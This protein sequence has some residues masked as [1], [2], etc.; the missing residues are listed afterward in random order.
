VRAVRVVSVFPA[1]TSTQPRA[2]R[3]IRTSTKENSDRTKNNVNQ[4][5]T[6][7]GCKYQVD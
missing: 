3:R 7:A 1:R 2:K 4:S 5:G 6:T